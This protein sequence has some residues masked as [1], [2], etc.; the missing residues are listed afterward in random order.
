LYLIL[1]FLSRL[2]GK[3]LDLQDMSLVHQDMILDHQGRNRNLQFQNLLD[4][5]LTLQLQNLLGMIQIL[6]LRNLLDKIQILL[7]LQLVVLLA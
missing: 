7:H 6:Q 1:Q 4:T 5:I 3:I 2:Q